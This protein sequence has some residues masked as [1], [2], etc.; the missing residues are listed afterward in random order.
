MHTDFVQRNYYRKDYGK[1]EKETLYEK[2]KSYTSSDC[3]PFHMPGHKRREYPFNESYSIDITEIDGFDD[4]HHPEGIIRDAMADAARIYKSDSSYFLVNG[5]T[6]GILSAISAV[7]NLGDSIL[8]ARNCH[9][10]VYN[11]LYLRNLKPYYVYP[12]PINEWGITGGILPEDVDNVLKR[13]PGIRA[14]VIVS[15][16]YEGVISDIEKIARVCHCYEIPLIVDEAHGAHFPFWKEGPKSALECGADCVIQSLHKTLPSLTQTAII[17]WKKGF[18][19][20][21]ALE[22]YLHIY[23]SS[24]PSYVFLAGIQSCIN[25]MEKTGWDRM[26]LHGTRMKDFVKQ[27]EGFQAIRVLDSSI[28]GCNGVYD[29]DWTRL[30]IWAPDH[31]G[32]EL[33]QILRDTYHLQM[34]METPDYVVAITSIADTE[35]GLKRLYKALWEIDQ[36]WFL[37]GG[38]ETSEEFQN[39]LECIKKIGEKN[40]ESQVLSPYESSL[41]KKKEI[42][43]KET[44]GYLS[45]E[46]AYIYP[47]GIPFLMPGERILQEHLD[48]FEFYKEMGFQI[49]GISDSSMKQLQV[50]EGFE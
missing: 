10:S 16:T 37:N 12:Q 32:D 6:G 1:M 19:E 31:K 34:E 11:T 45:A 30:V 21:E 36:E 25:Q 4:Y 28:V 44:K 8:I 42:P 5:S 38:L 39:V 13:N 47:P 50:I 18:M 9:K 2:L 20:K 7:T 48:I 14:V 46:T 3:Y 24:S 43:W 49:K 23:Q 27:C 41:C 33:Y 35:E 17:H 26:V 15:P 29:W 22:R 40:I